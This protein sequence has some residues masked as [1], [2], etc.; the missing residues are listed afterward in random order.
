MP[1]VERGLEREG[2]EENRQAKN[3]QYREA[4]DKLQEVMDNYNADPAQIPLEDLDSY[5]EAAKHYISVAEDQNELRVDAKVE[6]LA[7]QIV[8]EAEAIK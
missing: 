5:L 4:W 6:K 7:R 8:Q 1:E 2:F 3:E